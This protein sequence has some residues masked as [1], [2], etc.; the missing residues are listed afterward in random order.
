MEMILSFR[1]ESLQ[2]SASVSQIVRM[3]AVRDYSKGR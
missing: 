2:G 3:M 1:G